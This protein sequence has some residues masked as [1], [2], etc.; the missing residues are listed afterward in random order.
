MFKY[1]VKNVDFS[2][3]VHSSTDFMNMMNDFGKWWIVYHLKMYI[4][5]G[6]NNARKTILVFENMNSNWELTL[7]E[8]K[9]KKHDLFY[10]ELARNFLSLLNFL[11]SNAFKHLH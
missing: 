8:Y 11:F 9:L 10:S 6:V 7:K 5:D 4:V 2:I 3:S 1:I